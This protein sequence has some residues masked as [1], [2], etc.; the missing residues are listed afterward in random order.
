MTQGG[1]LR[2]AQIH[3]SQ[4]EAFVFAFYGGVDDVK[5]ERIVFEK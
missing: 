4:Y 2:L 3:S 5:D 1:L